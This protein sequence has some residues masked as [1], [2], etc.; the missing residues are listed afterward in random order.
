MKV[1]LSYYMRKLV[2]TT[3]TIPENLYKQV[4]ISASVLR[5]SFS[6]YVVQ[7]LEERIKG[8]SHSKK[9]V[10]SDPLKTLGRLSIGIKKIYKK[11]SDLYDEHIKR[12]MGY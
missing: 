9:R 12:K 3:I 2:R 11:R 4:K 5:E 1:L 8:K 6:S 10:F 7:T